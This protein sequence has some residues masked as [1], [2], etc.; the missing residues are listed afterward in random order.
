MMNVP[1]NRK[2]D[3]ENLL[4]QGEKI[5]ASGEIRGYPEPFRTAL[6]LAAFNAPGLV[7]G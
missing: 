2:P 3:I 1:D 4:D 7:T 5:G 6:H